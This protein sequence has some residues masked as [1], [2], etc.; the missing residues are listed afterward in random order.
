MWVCA[1]QFVFKEIY[2]IMCS[3]NTYSNLYVNLGFHGETR[4]YTDKARDFHSHNNS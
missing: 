4:G 3:V 1:N 2:V